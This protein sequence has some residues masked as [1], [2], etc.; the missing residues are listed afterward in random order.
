MSIEMAGQGFEAS[1]LIDFERRR[2]YERNTRPAGVDKRREF[3]RVLRDVSARRRESSIRSRSGELNTMPPSP[4]M[5]RG[6]PLSKRMN[7]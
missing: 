4:R 7:R 3:P 6:S 5:T 2:N 1:V